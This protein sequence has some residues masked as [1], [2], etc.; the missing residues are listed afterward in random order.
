MEGPAVS[1]EWLRKLMLV[2]GPLKP[3][4]GLSG[5]PALPASERRVPAGHY[6]KV[7]GNQPY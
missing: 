7:I 2:G 5:P 6:T 1:C 3:S 4:F